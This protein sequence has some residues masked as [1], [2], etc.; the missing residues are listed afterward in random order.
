MLRKMCVC[1]RLLGRD[2][3][4]K[5]AIAELLTLPKDYPYRTLSLR[6]IAVLQKNLKARQ[7]LSKDLREV[8]MALSITYEQIEAELLAKGREEGREEGELIRSRE[9]ALTML[10]EGMDPELVARLTKL[11]IST[12]E[13]FANEQLPHLED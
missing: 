5:R 7:N 4:Q 9:I 11:P 12:V 13:G 2:N 6:H 1:P 3:V 8:V 10:R